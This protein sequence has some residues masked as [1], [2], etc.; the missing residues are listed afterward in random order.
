MGEFYA[1]LCALLWAAAVILFRRS[2]ETVSPFALNLFRVTVSS[3]LLAATVFVAGR[4][5]FPE[6]S[7]EDLVRL[8]ISG[9]VAIAL[10]DTLFHRCLFTVGAGVTAIVDCLYSPLMILFAF[11][12][13]G[14]TIGP[15]QTGGMALVVSAV[16]VASRIRPLPGTTRRDLVKGV[17]YGAGAMT[18]LTLGV[19]VARPVLDNQDILWATAVRQIFALIVLWPLALILPGRRV[20]LDVFRPRL[21]WRFTV[22]GTILGSYLALIF[23]LAGM[24]H[25]QVGAAAILNQTSTVYVLILAT[26][27]LGEPFGRRK[28][29]ASALALAGIGFVMIG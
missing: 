8:F 23:W 1:L 18:S 6:V 25:T 15:W 20:R 16:L 24:K 12:L 4:D 3:A 13:L 26:F 28:A 17:L 7:T 22:P 21:D 19:V 5:P 9:V 29:A 11:V 10:A 27:F 2:G 14:E